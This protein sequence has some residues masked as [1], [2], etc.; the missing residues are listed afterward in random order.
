MK[1]IHAT[2]EKRN[3]GCDAWEITLDHKDMSDV[4]GVIETLRNP[5]YSGAYVCVKLPV[6]NLHMVH[7]L[8]DEGFRFLEVQYSLIEHFLPMDVDIWTESV[9]GRVCKEITK[10]ES[11]W[12]RIVDKIDPEMFE[13]DRISLDP[14]LGRDKACRRYQNWIMDMLKDPH[15]RMYVTEIDGLEVSFGVERTIGKRT[16]SI[17]GGMFSQCKNQGMGLALF[18][19]AKTSSDGRR[20]RTHISSNNIDVLRVHQ[21]CGRIIY[22][23]MY[24]FRKFYA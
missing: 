11:E 6:G 17:L 5:E 20:M 21:N 23:Q 7:A 14:L 19:N 12:R 13:T 9:E 15:V 4:T 3:L 1:I 8:E 18:A 22:K 24:V 16:Q 10:T 2:W